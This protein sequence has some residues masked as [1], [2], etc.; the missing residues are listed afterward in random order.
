MTRIITA[1]VVALA[2]SGQAQAQIK[3]DCPIVG[4]SAE[5]IMEARQLGMAM[6]ELIERAHEQ[7]LT[8]YKATIMAAYE[9]PRFDGEEYQQKAIDDFRNE[10][11]LA[12][13]KH[14]ENLN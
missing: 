11:E 7:S 12:C 14:N 10:M 2:V 5:N 3:L 13:Y 1:L 4:K 6:S 8:K 9:R